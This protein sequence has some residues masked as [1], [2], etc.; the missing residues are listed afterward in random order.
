MTRKMS[1]IIEKLFKL[2]GNYVI[3][4]R[5]SGESAERFLWIRD[6]RTGEIIIFAS[7]LEDAKEHIRFIPTPPSDCKTKHT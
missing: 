5:E 2:M 3:A 6:D 7:S 4:M 1:R